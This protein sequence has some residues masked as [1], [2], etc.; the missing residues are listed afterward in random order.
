MSTIS[1]C[2]SP[3]VSQQFLD[4]GAEVFPWSYYR[5]KAER[6]A[7]VIGDTGDVDT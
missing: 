3:K 1:R 2:S 4:A 5:E 6:V 7:V